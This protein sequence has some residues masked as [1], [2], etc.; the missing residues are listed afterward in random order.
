MTRPRIITGN[1]F[2]AA[3]GPSDWAT[4][5]VYYGYDDW[6]AS[7]LFS[8]W[9]PAIESAY[10]EM[11]RRHV[12][13]IGVTR[14]IVDRIGSPGGSIVVP[15]GLDPIG[16]NG[17]SQV[18]TRLRHVPRPWV[19][20]VGTIDQRLDLDAVRAT[21]A[22]IAPGTVLLVGMAVDPGVEAALRSIPNVLMEG[23]QPR[24][25]VTSLVGVADVCVMPHR[26]TD[27]TEAMS[28]L[29]LYEYVAGGRPVVAT[30]LGPVRDIDPSIA[31][32]APGDATGFATAVQAALGQPGMPEDRHERFITANSWAARRDAVLEFVCSSPGT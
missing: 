9:W 5:V 12:R 27:L 32:V 3:Y 29:K 16:W 30:D 8:P 2:V 18:P 11:A 15:N 21:A 17:R 1:P 26:R 13:V 14:N 31:L 4:S 20:Y 24:S 19:L 25:V 23:L 6:A 28:P 22:R 7:P 10:A